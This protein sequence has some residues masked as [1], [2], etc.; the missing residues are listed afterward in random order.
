MAEKYTIEHE[1]VE[2]ILGFI[3]ADK[4]ARRGEDLFQW[5]RDNR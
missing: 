3:L 1:T 4:I 5:W 2:N